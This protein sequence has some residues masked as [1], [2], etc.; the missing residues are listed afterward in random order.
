MNFCNAHGIPH[1]KFL[2]WDEDDR[3]KALAYL[4]EEGTKCGMC[5]T[6]EWEW[7]QE[8]ERGIVRPVRAYEPTGHFCMGCY[9]K[10]IVGEETGNEPGMSVRLVP[11][12]S[13]DAAKK[14]VAEE[15]AW[16]MRMEDDD[17]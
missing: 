11:A 5:G 7:E 13:M 10:S 2:E 12:N 9:L 15:A 17:G 3:N 14:I 1:S 16:R 6:A 4:F 8:D